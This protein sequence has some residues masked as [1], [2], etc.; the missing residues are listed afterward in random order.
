MVEPADESFYY[1]PDGE[2]LLISPCESVPAE[3]GD[4][5]VVPGDIAQLIHRIDA[6]TSLGIS[7]VVRS[8]TGLRTHPADGLPVVG[9]DAARAR[10]LLAGRA[11]RLRHPDLGGPGHA[12]RA[13]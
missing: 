2:H 6:V 5:Q 10:L 12:G 11:G 3:P 13:G 1:R 9:F 7:G 4:A 8:W